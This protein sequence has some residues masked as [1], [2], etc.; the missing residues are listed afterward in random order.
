MIDLR[1]AIVERGAQLASAKDPTSPGDLLSL[2][3]L[4]YETGREDLPLGSLFEGHVDA[5]Q[6]VTRYGTQA[7]RNTLSKALASHSAL[8][9][10]NAELSGEPLLLRNG[11]LTGGKSF[12]SGAG[13]LSHALVTAEHE[14]GRQLIL[15]DL[16]KAPP[17]I[18]RTFWRVVGMQRSETHIVR[19]QDVSVSP[20]ALIGM[21]GDYVRE[22]WFSG[23]ALRFTAVQAGGIAALLDGTRDHLTA[24]GRSGD[25]HQ[26]GRLA[27]LFALAQAASSA[28]RA[29]A[30]AWFLSETTRLPM[31]AAARD[32]VYQAGGEALRIAQEA[33]GA[34]AL[35]VDHP[36]SATIADLSMYLRQ[37]APDMQRMNVGAAVAAG[38]LR[39]AL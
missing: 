10:W 9:V 25:P 36:L 7:Q 2:L 21:P 5:V 27:A 32:A 38:T 23:G 35:F 1:A 3:R 24:V 18:D 26:S 12:A 19:W 34:Q 4:L 6:I 14:G 31:V 22:P 8:G 16:A 13:I 15:L 11:Q 30:S 39:A 33:V 29:A 20:D 37:P 28:V 17:V